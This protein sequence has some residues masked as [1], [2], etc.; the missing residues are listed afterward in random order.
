MDAREPINPADETC[1]AATRKVITVN[2]ACVKGER[3]RSESIGV[4]EGGI[5]YVLLFC[6]SRTISGATKGA[7][8][9]GLI[10]G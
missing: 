9:T 8:A 5:Y 10:Q 2:G 6:A 1:I 3:G 4:A 7:A